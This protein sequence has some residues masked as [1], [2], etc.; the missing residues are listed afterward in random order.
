MPELINTALNNRG[1]NRQT[2][3]ET[4]LTP[5]S[6]EVL[7][8]VY[9]RQNNEGV[10]LLDLLN[11]TDVILF[12]DNDTENPDTQCSI[13]QTRYE[14]NTI[15]RKINNCNHYYCINCLDRWLTTNNK[16]PQCRQL[17]CPDNNGTEAEI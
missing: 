1:D 11:N 4:F 7:V 15:I 13:C 6:N 17:I 3:I 10:K 8:N 16:C 5:N 9:N 2:F 14:E 12:K